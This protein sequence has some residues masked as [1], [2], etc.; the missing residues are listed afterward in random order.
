MTD[1][2]TIHV[3]ITRELAMRGER[4]VCARCP[5]ALAINQHLLPGWAAWIHHTQGTVS[6]GGQ[7]HTFALPE[8]AQQF[9]ATFDKHKPVQFPVTFDVKLPKRLV[10]EAE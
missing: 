5:V 3:T 10:K 1:L 6:K 9:V 7:V 2:T 8:V 4:Y